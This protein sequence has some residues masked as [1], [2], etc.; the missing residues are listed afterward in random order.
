MPKTAKRKPANRQL[1][2]AKFCPRPRLST[3]GEFYFCLQN[4]L[5]QT[6]L[7]YDWKLK[8]LEKAI[9]KLQ[10]STRSA[11]NSGRAP[12]WMLFPAFTSKCFKPRKDFLVRC[13]E[14][15]KQPDKKGMNSQCEQQ[16][17]NSLLISLKTRCMNPPSRDRDNDKVTNTAPWEQLYPDHPKGF[18]HRCQVMSDKSLY[19]SFYYSEVEIEISGAD[20]YLGMMYRRID[21]ATGS[22]S[23]S[24]TSA[25]SFSWSILRNGKGF[26]AWHSDVEMPLKMDVFGRI[27]VYPNYPRRTLSFYGITYDDVT[28]MHQFEYDF[29]EPLYLDFWLLKKETVRIM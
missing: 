21:Q 7:E 8:S 20:I 11:V 14:N 16:R 1:V 4:Y 18:E 28:L 23:N 27:G 26:S 9:L 5:L 12:G 15:E 2:G 25:N 19:L 22:E 3:R 10:N 29:V 24:C 13:R 6:H 17:P